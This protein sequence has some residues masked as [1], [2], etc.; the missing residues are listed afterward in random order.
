MGAASRP[1][2]RPGDPAQSDDLLKVETGSL[3]PALHRL[4][5][6]GWIKADWGVSQA[7]QRAKF[8]RLT[9]EGKKQLVREESRWTQLVNAIGRVMKP[10]TAPGPRS[11]PWVSCP[12]C[13]GD[14]ASSSTKRTSRT[15]SARTWRSRPRR[16][17]PTARTAQDAHYAALK[18][19][20]NV[21]LTTEAARRV[22]TPRWL[23]A[24]R[25]LSSDVRYAIRALA[26]NPASRYRRR[27][28]DARHRFERRRL[29]DAQ[30]HGAQRRSPASTGRAGLPSSTA[31]RAPAA[32]VRVSYPDYQYFR[33]HDRAFAGLVRH[34]AGRSVEPRA[35]ARS[36]RSVSGEVVTGNYFQVLG[37]RAAARSNAAALGRNRARAASRRRHQRRSLAPR[38]RRR[39]RHR[40]PDDR[41][42]QLPA[43]HRRRRRSVVSR[44]HRQLRRRSCSSR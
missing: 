7:N 29:H 27:R 26:K 22:W 23:E 28:A 43:H 25:D 40:R 16:A 2:H 20:G 38:L 33:D 21:T 30:G 1:R 11:E 42:Q 36:R 8:Y 24:L 19:F 4:V 17:S 15:R 9:P 31:R 44:H 39:S 13:S 6:R 18:E 37:V 12:G 3:Y 14:A 34:R 10:A 35:G 32:S 41:R 5:K